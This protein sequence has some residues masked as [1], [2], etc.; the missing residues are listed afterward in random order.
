MEDGHAVHHSLQSVVLRSKVALAVTYLGVLVFGVWILEHLS[1]QHAET[2]RYGWA[3]A[4]IFVLLAV[5]VSLHEIHLHAL[6]Y[7]S[8]LQ[9]F[10]IRILWM[11]PIYSLESF[12][13]LRFKDQKE[14]L[15]TMREAY[16]A[17]V[18]FSYFMLLREYLSRRQ[19]NLSP[20]QQGQCCSHLWPFKYI[21]TPWELGPPF[22]TKTLTGV[23]QY[24]FVRTAFAILVLL[25]QLVGVYGEGEWHN[26]YRL[27][28]WQMIAVNLSQTWALYCLMLFYHEHHEALLPLRPFGK[29]MSIKCVIFFSFWQ[30]VLI[31]LLAAFGVLHETHGALD[32]R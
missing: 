11:V 32:Y 4:G 10:Y 8:P 18:V 13:A 17:W 12:L 7:V 31:S 23:Y 3:V 29:F 25:A 6:H 15:E 19:E 24:V 16:E 26:L 27:F 9:R 21:L 2:H 20:E 30:S 28:V 22:E 14:Y 1:R 5:P